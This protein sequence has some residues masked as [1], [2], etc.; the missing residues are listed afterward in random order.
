[1]SE[2]QQEVLARIL[3]G[4]QGPDSTDQ[5]AAIYELSHLNYSS[6]AIVEKLEDLAFMAAKQIVRQAA[7]GA[8][9]LRTSQFVRSQALKYLDPRQRLAILAEIEAW[10]ERG[11]I[12]QEQAEVLVRRYDF[13]RKP[14]EPAKSPA[15][16]IAKPVTL[17]P[18]VPAVPKP[19]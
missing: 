11:L 4:L 15:P 19:Y 2:S 14:V 9:D 16:Q 6:T 3:K 13:N 18:A 7:L 8:L 5:L 17:Q 12:Q 1:M 10:K